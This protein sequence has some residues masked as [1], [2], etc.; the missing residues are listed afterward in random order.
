[1]LESVVE[2][3]IRAR[4]G[5]RSRSQSVFMWTVVLLED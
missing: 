5:P 3:D 4:F 2:V 1:M